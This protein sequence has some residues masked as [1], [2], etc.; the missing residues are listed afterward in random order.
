MVAEGHAQMA[1]YEAGVAQLA[2]A[3]KTIAEGEAKLAE[4]KKKQRLSDD[5]DSD[6]EDASF[7]DGGPTRYDRD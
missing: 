5:Y 1:A 2:E 3:E 4:A 6:E 7:D